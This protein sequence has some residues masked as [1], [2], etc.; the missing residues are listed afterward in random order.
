[1]FKRLMFNSNKRGQALIFSYVIIAVLIVVS[2]ALLSKGINERNL[3]L[4]NKLESEAFF[5]AEGG[6]EDAINIFTSAIANHQIPNDAITFNVVTTY[7]TFGAAVVNSWI[8]R[9]EDSDRLILEGQTNIWVRNYEIISTAVHPQN[10]SIRITIHQ[11]IARRLIP[12]FQHAV[13]YNDDLEVLPGANMDLSGR[14]HCNKDIYLDAESGRTL[15]IDSLSLHSAGSIYNQRKDTGNPIAGEVSIRVDKPGA[16]Q[17]ENMSNLDSDDPNWAALST[18]RWQGSVQSAVHGVTKLTAPAVASIQPDG[19]YASQANVVIENGVV[20]KGG[21]ILIEGE[22]YP[23]GALSTTT[24]FYNN[25]EAKNIKMTDIDLKKLS[26]Y[27]ADDP[28]GSPSF[29][30][31]LPS[32]G[33]LYATRN[34]AGFNEESGIRLLN[35]TEIYSGQGLTV[36]S[37][38]PVYIKG[39]FNTANEKPTSVICDSLNLLSNN[40]NDVNSKSWPNRNA[41]TTTVNCAF[42]AGVDETLSSRY[43]GGLEN[44]PRLHENW[45]GI[46]LNIKG[47]FVE[48]WES[49]IAQG[50]W[51][52]GDPQYTA[53][54]RNWTYNTNFNNPANL[55]PFT[56]W[57]VEAQR[58]AWWKE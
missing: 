41:A 38:N 18:N 31:N 49:S 52:Y 6:V 15:T 10:S 30:N 8:N 42:I 19:Y 51:K 50:A 23:A 47:S 54:R 57:A 5:L 32:N 37:N 9:L 17:F 48:L 34:D 7:N 26:G 24:T 55:P 43:N 22:D 56:P 3:S 25:R 14:I 29:P 53:P 35:G 13:F 4:R 21:I 27:A 2:S 40:W 39:D 28:P 36:V 16:P 46:N 11:I 44:Y 12:T 1:M 20:K 58:V 45:S 33:L